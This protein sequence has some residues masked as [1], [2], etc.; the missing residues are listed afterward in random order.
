MGLLLLVCLQAARARS[1]WAR[2]SMTI[3]TPQ[4][5][6]VVQRRAIHGLCE[7]SVRKHCRAASRVGTRIRSVQG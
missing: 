7:W 6:Q 4:V 2:T 3:P 5:G 1:S